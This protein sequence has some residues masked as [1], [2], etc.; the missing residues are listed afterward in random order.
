MTNY[1]FYNIIRLLRLLRQCSKTIPI[2]KIWKWSQSIIATIQQC[3]QHH[4]FNSRQIQIAT[5]T[6]NIIALMIFIAYCRILIQKITTL[7]SSTHSTIRA[8]MNSIMILQLLI[9]RHIPT[10]AQ[11]RYSLIPQKQSNLIKMRPINL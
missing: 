7:Y 4:S 3:P 5:I 8:S 2:I 10:K 9:L 1:N 6:T 11:E